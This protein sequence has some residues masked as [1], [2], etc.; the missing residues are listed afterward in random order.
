VPFERVHVVMGDTRLTPNQGKST[1]SFNVVRGSQPVRV[2]AA[3]AR[4]ALLRMAAEKLRVSA[5]DL[6][7]VDGMV[8]PKSGAGGKRRSY[9]ELI[10]NGNFSITL[11]VGGTSEEDISRGILLKPKAPLKAFKD[12]K[13]VGKSFPRVDLPA[14]IAGTFEYVHNV[15]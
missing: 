6:E 11:E 5:T 4:A 12:Y 10:G 15:R 7:V 8:R 9:G 14:K 13:V 1:A 2:A 3:E